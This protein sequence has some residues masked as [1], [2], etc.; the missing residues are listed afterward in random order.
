MTSLLRAIVLAQLAG[1]SV[2]FGSAYVGQWRPHEHVDFEACLQDETGRC[3]DTKQ[4]RTHVP[5]RKYW[6]VIAT[7]PGSMGG[8]KAT[9]QGTSTTLLRFEPSFEYVRGHGRWAIGARASLVYEAKTGEGELPQDQRHPQLASFPITAVGR[10]SLLPRLSAHAGL[11][12]SLF[13]A[14]GDERSAVAGRGLAGV[15]LALS[16][17]HSESF[18]VLTVEVDRMFVQLDEPYRSTGV[19]GNLGLF[20]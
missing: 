4:V 1:C 11:G 9:Y 7:L 15:Q 20:F 13:S 14:R 8:S 18:L 2:G 12:Y 19:T 5:G 3:I 6:A 10:V 16:R 17:T